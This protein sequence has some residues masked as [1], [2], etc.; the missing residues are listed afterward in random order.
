MYSH[1]TRYT[2]IN[3][4]APYHNS[5]AGTSVVRSVNEFSGPSKFNAVRTA[6]II[7]ILTRD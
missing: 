1:N 3:T 7:V 6:A 5:I 2:H 4:T